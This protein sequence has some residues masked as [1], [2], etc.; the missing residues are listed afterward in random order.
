MNHYKDIWG[1]NGKKDACVLRKVVLDYEKGTEEASYR[2]DYEGNIVFLL[3][4]LVLRE[5]E[6]IEYFKKYL[7]FDKLKTR[8]SDG[9]HVWETRPYVTKFRAVDYYRLKC[10]FD[11]ETRFNY[12]TETY[13]FEGEW[14]GGDWESTIANVE[15]KAYEF[16]WF[17]VKHIEH[18]SNMLKNIKIND[19]SFIDFWYEVYNGIYN[20]PNNQAK[21]NIITDED[22]EKAKELYERLSAQH[23]ELNTSATTSNKST[24][25]DEKRKHNLLSLMIGE[26]PQVK[27]RNKQQYNADFEIV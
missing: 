21:K 19:K 12:M 27:A 23:K 22:F 10:E 9:R 20:N 11:I 8:E 2:I 18:F 16:Y 26:E 6:N 4:E 5:K 1:F 25:S 14:Y 24:G 7:D 15:N 17:D 3:E 13:K